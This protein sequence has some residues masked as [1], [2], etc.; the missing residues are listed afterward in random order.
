MPS[1]A[2]SRGQRR[3]VVLR[4]TLE[5]QTRL[6]LALRATL[7]SSGHDPKS[8]RPTLAWTARVIYVI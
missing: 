2:R 4:R 8:G 5:L 6:W 7:R 1:T 3:S